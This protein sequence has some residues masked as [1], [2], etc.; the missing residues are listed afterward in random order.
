M[1]VQVDKMEDPGV[2]YDSA[3]SVTSDEDDE[4]DFDE[5]F[6]DKNDETLDA[7]IREESKDDFKDDG[8]FQTPDR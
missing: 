3:D 1:C 2:D 4:E 8:V 5:D 6:L 7:A